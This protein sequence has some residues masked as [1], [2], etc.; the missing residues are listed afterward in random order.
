MHSPR[1]TYSGR[2]LTVILSRLTSR[3]HSI[4]RTLGDHHVLTSS[5]IASAWFT[6]LTRAQT[7]LVALHRLGL[8][9][10]WRTRLQHG[11]QQWHYTLSH[12]GARIHAA[13]CDQPAPAPASVAET[14]LKLGS[15]PKLPHLLGANDFFIRLIAATRDHPRTA[16][17]HW[18]NETAAAARAGGFVRPDARAT[19][20]DH[21]T[22]IDFWYEHDRGTEP[23]TTLESK[24]DKYGRILHTGTPLPVL[25]ELTSHTREQH[26]HQR[27]A[28]HHYR[29]TIATTTNARAS[30]PAGRVW[31]PLRQ[32][33]H[34]ATLID[35]QPTRSPRS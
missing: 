24:L 10:R 33:P 5:Q 14:I 27:L 3:D 30:D 21:D 8:L 16:L 4:I 32:L 28:N 11:S 7:R 20:T 2:D 12:L 9:E 25:F 18:D 15:S 1:H 34:T 35:L 17:T 29:F 13:T 22:T 6:S 26:L 19:Y 31:W 23:L